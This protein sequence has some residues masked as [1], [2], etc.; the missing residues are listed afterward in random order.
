[1]FKIHAFSSCISSK[2]FWLTVVDINALAK[3]ETQSSAYLH[4]GQRSPKIHYDYSVF[5]D[6]VVEARIG[7]YGK[8]RLRLGDPKHDF[9][10]PFRV[11]YVTIMLYSLQGAST[12]NEI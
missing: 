12:R 1:V 2:R 8:Q 11:T 10:V 5:T 4:H 3:L 9:W 7:M 6:R